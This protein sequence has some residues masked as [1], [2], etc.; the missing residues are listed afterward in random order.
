M[1]KPLESVNLQLIWANL[2]ELEYKMISLIKMQLSFD[3]IK[4]I[5]GEAQSIFQ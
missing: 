2:I 4:F 1:F 5:I 3:N